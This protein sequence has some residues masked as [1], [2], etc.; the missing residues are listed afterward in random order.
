MRC[1][2]GHAFHGIREK[3]MAIEFSDDGVL[4]LVLS[5]QRCAPKSWAYGVFVGSRRFGVDTVFFYAMRPDQVSRVK[6]LQEQG[7]AS[8]EIIHFITGVLR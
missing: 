6:Q 7:A 4:A 1:Q 2:Y 5:C 8:T 3:G